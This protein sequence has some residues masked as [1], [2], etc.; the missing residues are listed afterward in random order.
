MSWPQPRYPLNWAFN[1]VHGHF[2]APIFPVAVLNVERNWTSKG[3]AMPDAGD[4]IGMV[5]LDLH[6]P[7]ASVAQLPPA[8]LDGDV[9]L[10]QRKSG[11][12]TLDDDTEAFSVGFTSGQEAKHLAWAFLVG[13]CTRISWPL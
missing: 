3:Q 5:L 4:D 10:T 2:F 13:C 12:Y 1:W 11:R 7:A 8:E 6:S 9:G